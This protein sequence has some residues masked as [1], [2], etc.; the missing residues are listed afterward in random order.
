MVVQP[1][2]LEG[3]EQGVIIDYNGDLIYAYATPLGQGTNNQPEVKA[4][5]WGLSWCL[6]N[7]IQQVMLEVDAELLVRW[8]REQ[9]PIPWNL[10]PL[11]EY[12]LKDIS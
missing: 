6:N 10:Q 7:G 3:L 5:I 12:L 1:Q 11:V 2:I 8:T 9:I 4:A